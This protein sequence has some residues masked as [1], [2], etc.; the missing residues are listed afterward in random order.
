MAAEP[1]SSGMNTESRVRLV[2]IAGVIALAACALGLRAWGFGET[3][4]GQFDEGVYAFTGLGLSDPSQPQRMFPE[5][6]KFSPPVYVFL[7]ALSYLV[8][9][10]SDHSAILVNVIVGTL[11]VLGIWWVTRRW[12]GAAAAMGAAAF[13]ALSEVHVILSRTALT[14]VT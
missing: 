6:Q 11:S 3:G 7:V 13:T 2:E 5:Q 8:R 14:D 10:A 4:L 12:F 9:G 1:V